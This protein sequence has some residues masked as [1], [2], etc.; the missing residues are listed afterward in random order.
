MQQMYFLL[1]DY[2]AIQKSLVWSVLRA[3]GG[4]WKTIGMSRMSSWTI[5]TS[6]FSSGMRME[7]ADLWQIAIRQAAQTSLGKGKTLMDSMMS[8]MFTLPVIPLRY[9]SVTH[10]YA[11]Y[12]E[13]YL[14]KSILPR[15]LQGLVLAVSKDQIWL[16]RKKNVELYL[17]FG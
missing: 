12:M 5:V 1:W 6:S 14:I 7:W 9:T 16:N 4:P 2:V 10:F 13:L 15:K 17:I 8:I 3:P 11:Y